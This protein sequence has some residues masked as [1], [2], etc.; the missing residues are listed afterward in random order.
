MLLFWFSTSF[1]DNDNML[2]LI[3]AVMILKIAF[4]AKI[5]SAEYSALSL[6]GIN[7]GMLGCSLSAQ[8]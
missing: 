1:G 8:S 4:F 7:R 6:E 5:T 2:R 3:N